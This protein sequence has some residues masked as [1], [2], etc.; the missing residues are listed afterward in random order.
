MAYTIEIEGKEWRL[1]P[2]WT[3]ETYMK[4]QKFDVELDW[5]WPQ[6]ISVASGAPADLLQQVNYSVKLD[7]IKI[8]SS[9][10]TPMW[11]EHKPMYKGYKFIDT[12]KLTIGQL[13]DLEVAF[14]RGLESNLD[15]LVATLYDAPRAQVQQW[16]YEVAWTALQTWLHF[17]RDFL[18]NYK[19]LFEGGDPDGSKQ[20]PAHGWFDILMI[21]SDEKFLN[22]QHV[23]DRP[24]Y[25][26]FNF[27]AW[28]KDQARKAELEIKKQ[29]LARK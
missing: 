14:G 1:D 24:A 19:D 6:V 3:V 10:L 26:A 8:I 28:K 20:D 16:S 4:L 5:T 17:R 13:V 7:A 29:Q 11:A 12:T 15:W 22:I 21:L 9:A 25:E 18:D 27:L 23:V 2:E